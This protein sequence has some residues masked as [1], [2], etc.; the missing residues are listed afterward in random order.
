[1]VR[2]VSGKYRLEYPV[3]T[4]RFETTGAIT[5]PRVSRDGK[6]IAFLYHPQR[7][8]DRGAVMLI[9]ADGK[10]RT[11]SDGWEAEQGLAWTPSGDTVWFSASDATS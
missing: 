3:G 11:L 10:A 5:Q 2:V 1:M 9:D 7:G 6:R 4:A 8:D